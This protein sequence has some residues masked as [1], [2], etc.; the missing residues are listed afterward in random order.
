[1]KRR[2]F[3]IF[4]LSIIIICLSCNQQLNHKK[5]DYHVT[6]VGISDGDTFKGLTDN[7]EEIRFRIYGIDAPEKKQPYSNK[8][9]QYLSDLIHKKKVGIIVQQQRDR[10]G[11]PIVWVYTPTG[12]D[13]GSEMLKAGMAWHFKKYDNSKE[14]ADLENSAREKQ[15]GLWSDKNPVSP[16]N[17]RKNKKK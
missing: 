10:Y 15:I 16:W 6:V 1:M 14:Y 11:R 8:S 13:V 9:K 12:K 4:F 2:W 17:F 5:Y 3:P 7:K